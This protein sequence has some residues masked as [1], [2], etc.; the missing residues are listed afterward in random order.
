MNGVYLLLGG[1][2]GDRRKSLEKA[3]RLIKS[4]FKIEKK[5]SI[6]ESAA[7][8]L[9]DQ[10]SF[11]NQVLLG[12][13]DLSAEQLLTAVLAVEEK[14]G[15]ERIIKWG[16]RLIDIDIL[17]INQVILNSEQLTVPHPYIQER[18]FTLIPIVELSPGLQHPI[19]KKTQAQLLSCCEDH[20]NVFPINLAN[21]GN[22]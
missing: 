20:L 18:R 14:M 16:E 5:S 12:S 22:L 13:T 10:P 7:W 8:G 3:T 11:Y 4:F 15:R 9:E 21:D 2:L 6:Y 19:I 1:N 17:Y